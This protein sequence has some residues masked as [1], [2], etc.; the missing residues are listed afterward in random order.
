[1]CRKVKGME[2]RKEEVM[3]LVERIQEVFGNTVSIWFEIDEKGCVI[4]VKLE[5][6]N[7]CMVTEKYD[8]VWY[9]NS[10][11]EKIDNS[12][13]DLKMQEYSQDEE[14]QDIFEMIQKYEIKSLSERV[15][16]LVSN[17]EIEKIE[18]VLGIEYMG[19]FKAREVPI[20]LKEYVVNEIVYT[21]LRKKG[22]SAM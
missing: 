15:M 1:M 20:L 6:K 16:H 22:L 10:T 9:C 17:P 3:S 11:N 13:F 14:I 8:E 18:N 4:N 7:I 2:N 21:R 19:S 5:G 12:W